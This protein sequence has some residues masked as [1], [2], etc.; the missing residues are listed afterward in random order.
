MA[1][2]RRVAPE[3]SR[4]AEAFVMSFLRDLYTWLHFSLGN[5]KEL[6]RIANMVLNYRHSPK[7]TTAKT[8]KE[9]AKTPAKKGKR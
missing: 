1:G 4:P 7:C 5:P 8:S 2:Q 6:N 3:A 9:K